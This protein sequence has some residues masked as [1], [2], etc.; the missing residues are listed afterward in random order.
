M[1]PRRKTIA[2]CTCHSR[3]NQQWLLKT[4]RTLGFAHWVETLRQEGS[5][6]SCNSISLVKHLD[7]SPA[8]YTLQLGLELSEHGIPCEGEASA[9][10]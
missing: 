3:R 7:K 9:D 4:L 5:T 2:R 8:Q 10:A 6:P 1:P